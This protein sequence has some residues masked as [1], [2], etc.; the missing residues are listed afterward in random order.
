M[1]GYTLAEMMVVLLVVGAVAVVAVPALMAPLAE[2]RLSAAVSE[3][4]TALEFARM[5]VIGSGRP[6]R[7]TIDD[8]ADTILVEQFTTGINLLGSEGVL[9]EADV[10]GGDFAPMANPLNRSAD[11]GISLADEDRF[12]GVE[13]AGATFGTD[14]WVVFDVLGIPSSGGAVI[15]VSG[16][17]QVVVT[18]SPVTG[19]VSISD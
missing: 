12:R 9:D 18:V 1:R 17:H 4:V 8:A 16:A 10:E 13:I 14:D 2:A 15:L 3:V 5:T 6:T 11:Y 7:V 19:T